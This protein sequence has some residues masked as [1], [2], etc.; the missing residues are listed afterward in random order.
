MNELEFC[1][2]VFV[3]LLQSS[4]KIFS[5][6]EKPLLV[7]RLIDDLESVGIYSWDMAEDFVVDWTQKMEK[8]I[9]SDTCMDLVSEG[10]LEL[11]VDDSGEFLFSKP[12]E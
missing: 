8:E 3:G 5:N 6:Q 9:L 7:E 4:S 12:N 1:A 11:S 10:L 2:D